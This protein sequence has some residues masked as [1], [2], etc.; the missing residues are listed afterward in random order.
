MLHRVFPAAS[1]AAVLLASGAAHA[2]ALKNAPVAASALP[3]LP[4]L[5]GAAATPPAPPVS[6]DDF[7]TMADGVQARVFGSQLFTGAFAAARPTRRSDYLV[8]PGDQVAVRI[9]G[10]VNNDALQTVDT[11]GDL[12]V[13]GVGP[14]HVG[15]VPVSKLQATV[16]AAVSR[17]Y[18]STVGVYADVLQGGT[19]GVFLTGDVRRPGRYLGTPG[20]S[21]LYFL[22]Q[23]GGVN[24]A[25]GSFRAVAVHRDGKTVAT[26]DFYDFLTEGR[27]R[28]FAFED[29][30]VI[31]VPPQGA[32]VAVS[33]DAVSPYAFEAPP[34]QAGLSGEQV[35]R[36]ARPQS[37]VTSVGVSKVRGGD[38]DAAYFPVSEFA[39]VQ[40]RNGDHVLLKS[41]VFTNTISVSI[42]GDL[43]AP[44]IFVLPRDARLSDLLA[45]IPLEGT[46]IEPTYVHIQRASVARAQKVA[47]DKALDNL[48]RA[49]LTTPTLS[50]AGAAAVSAQSAQMSLFVEKAKQ[51]QPIGNVAVYVDGQ[52]NDLHLQNGDIVIF[53]KKSDVVMVAGE[54]LNPGAFTHA[55]G[56]NVI[57][58]VNRAGGATENANRKRFVLRRP[59]GTALVVNARVQP[60]PGDEIVVVPQIVNRNFLLFKDLTTVIFQMVT[61]TAAV[62]A[63]VRR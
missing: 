56:L 44:S 55:A 27:I 50:G 19:L 7:V 32:L 2:Q 35:L 11:S 37:T 28:A 20:D 62:V 22:D 5:T 36:L 14:V 13:Q 23:A 16:S 60:R 39:S 24:P 58:Y 41:D 10:A 15:G 30:D 29:G 18:T 63:V 34:G 54:A 57:G 9:F 26:F 6:A 17:I 45:Q 12:F 53:P 61:S 8:Q 25:K 59:D 31:F 46:D 38:G 40:L 47:L 1:L 52:F 49:V 33:G 48:E 3:A 43:K 42:Q 21:A 4:S 51:A